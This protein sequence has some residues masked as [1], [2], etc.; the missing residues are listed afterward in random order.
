MLSARL[1]EYTVALRYASELD[2]LKTTLDVQEEIPKSY[3]LFVWTE[4]LARTIRAEVAW[5]NGNLA[6]A[7]AEIEQTHPEVFWTATLGGLIESETYQRYMRG[8]LLAEMGR[9]QEALRWL[10]TLGQG[11][12]DGFV[13]LAPKHLEIGK[14]YESMGEREKAIEHYGRFVELWQD[15]EPECQPLLEEVRER[16]S[17]LKL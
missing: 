17:R 10:G 16:I 5:L 7:L 4:D 13:Y 8:V 11:S 3:A 15:C 2:S 14:V 1:G 6:E 12:G 9:Y